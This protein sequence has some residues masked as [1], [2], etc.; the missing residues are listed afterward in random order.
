MKTIWKYHI[1][2]GQ[3]E[4]EMPKDAKILSAQLQHNEFCVW[5]LV[6]PEKEKEIRTIEIFGTGLPFNVSDGKY[7][8][9]DTIQHGWFVGHIFEII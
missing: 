3:N 1:T 9:I 8:F 4:Y 6:D 7:K 5:A 2:Y